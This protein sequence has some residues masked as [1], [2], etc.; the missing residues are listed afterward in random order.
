MSVNRYD[1]QGDVMAINKKTGRRPDPD[2]TLVQDMAD[3]STM[4]DE[5]ID[6]ELRSYG[7]DPDKAIEKVTTTVRNKMNEWEKRGIL[8]AKKTVAH[9]H[10]STPATNRED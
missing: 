4:S 2:P 9:H 5:E 8:H 7:I 1:L 10:A 6:R 3:I